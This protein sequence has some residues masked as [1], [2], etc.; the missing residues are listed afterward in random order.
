MSFLDPS[1]EFEPLKP[2]YLILFF[3]I[4]EKLEFGFKSTDM[5]LVFSI[6]FDGF[7]TAKKN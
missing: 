7:S 6:K 5:L 1:P 4:Y 2:F 3:R